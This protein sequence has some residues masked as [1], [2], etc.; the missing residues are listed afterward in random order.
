MCL[1]VPMRVVEIKGSQAS[2]DLGGVK[3]WVNL[4]LLEDIKIND[5]IVVHA[6]FA[7]QKLDQKEA[8]ETL[9]VLQEMIDT[10]DEIH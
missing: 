5:Y 7:I 6:G 3:R 8:E 10:R 1:A 9:A 2:A 4:A